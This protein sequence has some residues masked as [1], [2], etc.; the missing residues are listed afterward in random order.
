MRWFC[1]IKSH[2]KTAIII[3]LTLTL[4]DGL[5]TA[6]SGTYGDH[7]LTLKSAPIVTMTWPQQAHLSAHREPESAVPGLL[8]STQWEL[9][10]F[11]PNTIGFMDARIAYFIAYFN[12]ILCASLMTICVI[13]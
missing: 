9:S 11:F 10:S 2:W 7:E 1:H 5:G 3:P 13:R 12:A 4:H 6:D 8:R